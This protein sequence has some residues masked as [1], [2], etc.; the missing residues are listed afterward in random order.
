MQR[1]ASATHTTHTAAAGPVLPK[2]HTT[3]QI[4]TPNK[5]KWY[6]NMTLINIVTSFLF[7]ITKCWSLSNERS[8]QD[9]KQILQQSE[10]TMILQYPTMYNQN[11]VPDEQMEV[12]FSVYPKNLWR[13]DMSALCRITWSYVFL[14][15]NQSN[16]FVRSCSLIAK[17]AKTT[18]QSRGENIWN[19]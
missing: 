9:K 2:N 10:N 14:G 8:W 3:R 19:F 5:N 13:Q 6:D 7:Y 12:S 18:C 15:L 16:I 1:W 11:F 4:F 17:T